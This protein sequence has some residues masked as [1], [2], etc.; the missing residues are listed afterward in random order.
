MAPH[1][2]IFGNPNDASRIHPQVGPY[3]PPLVFAQR[4][5]GRAATLHGLVPA[6]LGV[7]TPDDINNCCF[8]RKVLKFGSKRGLAEEWKRGHLACAWEYKAPASWGSAEGPP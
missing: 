3:G 7:P 8:E 1:L 5:A 2:T 4:A 6:A